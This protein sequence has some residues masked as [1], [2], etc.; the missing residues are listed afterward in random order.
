MISNQTSSAHILS[1]PLMEGDYIWRVLVKSLYQPVEPPQMEG[2][3]NGSVV[4]FRRTIPV[5]PGE[6]YGLAS[7][8]RWVSRPVELQ[9]GSEYIACTPHILRQLPVEPRKWRVITSRLDK[10]ASNK[11]LSNP[12]N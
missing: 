3:Y 10:P 12:T 9:I 8:R 6:Y 1:N 4:G 2:E 11:Y 5:E 7:I